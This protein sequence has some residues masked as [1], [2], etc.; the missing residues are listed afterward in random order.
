MKLNRRSFLQSVGAAGATASLSGLVPGVT[1]AK[2]RGENRDIMAKRQGDTVYHSCLRNCADRCLLKFTVQNGRATYVEGAAEQRKTGTCPCVKGMTYIQYTYS[3]DR[4]LHPM[5]RVGAKGSG[6]WRRISWDDAYAKIADRFK[7]IIEE[8]GSQAILP[9]SYSGNY[10]AIGMYGAAERFFNKINARY[11]D[12]YVCAYSGSYGVM[13]A[14][15]TSN[16]PDPEDSVYSDLY[17]SHGWNEAA[18]NV[19]YLKYINIA[20]DKGC[21]V[22]VVNPIRTPLASQAD[23]HIQLRPGTDVH[24]FAAVMKYMI[25]ND[26]HDKAY[27]KANTK[28]FDALVKQ[29]KTVS[30][31][32]CLRISNVGN[33]DFMEFVKL[34]TEAKLAHWR[35]GYGIVRNYTG[36]RIARAACLLHAVG[37]HYGKIGNGLSYDNMQ[38]WGCGDH[39]KVRAK[40]L[41]TNHDVGHVNITELA[42]ALDPVNPIAYDKPCDPVKAMLFYNGNPAAMAPDVNKVLAHMKREDLFVVGFDFNMHDSMDVCDIILPA[43]TQ[44]ET[45]DIIGSYGFFDLQVCDQVIEPLGESKSNWTFF[46]ELAKAMGYTD[47]EFDETN[48]DMIRQFM[49]SD[50]P[51]LVNANIDYD[52]IMKEK[53]IKVWEQRP[54]LADGKFGTESGKI[55][56][57]SK[58]MEKKH[59]HPVLDLG[60]VED[61]MIP[62]E[63]NLPFRMVSPAL[64]QRMNC[65][66]YN[67][68]Y[69]RNFPA[70]TV[71]INPSDAAARGIKDNDKVRVFNHRGEVFLTAVVSDQVDTGVVLTVKN[72]LRRFNPNGSQTCTNMLTTDRLADLGGCSAYHS[73]NV[74]IQKA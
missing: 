10:G 6:K 59:F 23:L 30:I 21:K 19:H 43:A 29:L 73:T 13:S 33:D 16:G 38:A 39:D 28:D 7:S 72:N 2:V 68:K 15:G 1:N 50:S 40:H 34:Y 44:F 56:F 66:F 52:R 60:Q 5:E 22:I 46:S 65:E 41:R 62:E 70:Y 55:E 32:E 71:T 49:S 54:F 45:S 24:F 8:H 47:P 17:I 25:D 18:T 14:L 58:Y 11:L 35:L 67:V 69:I 42:K 26:L 4:I 48:D 51:H 12:R 31:D 57:K 9:Y 20:R 36:G 3:P 37:G 63:R 64:I 53:F 61:W 74:D 27:I